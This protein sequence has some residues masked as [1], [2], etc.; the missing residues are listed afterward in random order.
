MHGPARAKPSCPPPHAHLHTHPLPI[1][2]TRNTPPNPIQPNQCAHTQPSQHPAST[3]PTSLTEYVPGGSLS[4]QLARFGPLPEPLVALYTRQLLL[5]LAYLHAQRT[6]HRDVK[7]GREWGGV[8]SGGVAGC[9]GWWGGGEWVWGV[10][11]GVWGVG[12]WGVA[13][14]GCG[15]WGVGGGGGGGVGGAVLWGVG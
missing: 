1:P 15:V 14:S 8:G 6:V 2:T 7:V 3:H 12:G 5:G 4:S 13:G 10:G 11:G 9:A